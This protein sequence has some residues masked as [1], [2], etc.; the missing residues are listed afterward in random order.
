[1]LCLANSYERGLRRRTDT[2]L[3]R[4]VILY[5]QIIDEISIAYCLTESYLFIRLSGST[6]IAGGIS[7]EASEVPVARGQK[8]RRYGRGQD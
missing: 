6:R 3:G 1:M 7:A 5:H 8:R 2:A 4:R